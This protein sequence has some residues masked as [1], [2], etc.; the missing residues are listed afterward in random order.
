MTPSLASHLMP[1]LRSLL[2]LSLCLLLAAVAVVVTSKSSVFRLAAV[3][4]LLLTANRLF[5]ELGSITTS[6][7]INSILVGESMFLLLQ[8]IN[9]VMFSKLDSSQLQHA[10]VL[11]AQSSLSSKVR[12]TTRLLLNLR[13]IGTPWKAKHVENASAWC[14]PTGDSEKGKKHENEMTP[15]VCLSSPRRRYMLRQSLILCWQYMF[16]DVVHQSSLASESARGSTNPFPMDFEFQYFG[17]SAK[18]W[19]SRV[20]ISLFA[21]LGPARVQLDLMYRLCGLSAV[22]IGFSEPSDWPPLFGSIKEAYSL[23]GFWTKYWHQLGQWPMTSTSHFI[24]RNVIRLPRDARWARW[25]R[26]CHGFLVFLVSG[27]L[28]AAVNQHVNLPLSSQLGCVAFFASFAFGIAI[29]DLVSGT[30]MSLRRD[31]APSPRSGIVGRCLGGLGNNSAAKVLGFVWVAT[32]MSLTAPWMLF[33]HIRL[34]VKDGWLVPFSL[35]RFIGMPAAQ[36]ILV[37]GGL[38]TKVGISGKI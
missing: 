24:R 9:F 17:L 6:A 23:Q 33:S 7:T 15:A 27:L 38:V 3:P 16:L 28:H 31:S 18:Q 19:A 11:A 29:E 26:Y 20:I 13:G 12:Q 34:P 35:T 22:F 8:C 32:W 1:I 5:H 37:L 36:M 2:H 21:G 10:G 30:W 25:H 14:S 4:C